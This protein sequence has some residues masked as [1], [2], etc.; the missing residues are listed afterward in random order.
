MISLYGGGAEKS[1]LTIIKMLQSLGYN[2]HVFS[3]L[4][5]ENA[6]ELKNNFKVYYLD[7]ANIK[8]PFS[9]QK[10]LALRRFLSD[11]KYNFIIDGRTRV[12]VIKEFFYQKIA[13]PSVSKKVFLVHSYHIYNYIFQN[14]NWNNFFYKKIH[15]VTVAKEIKNRLQNELHLKKVSHIPNALE[16]NDNFNQIES[17]NILTQDYI[18]YF[19]R[20]VD[21][22]KNVSFLIR[23]YLA[24]SLS[25]KGIKF[26]ILGSGIDETMLK[27][28][29]LEANKSDSV[30]FKSF[31]RNPEQYIKHAV[32]TVMASK[33]EGFPMTLIESLHLGIPVIATNFKSGPSEIISNG[34]NGILLQ[35]QDTESFKLA[36]EKMCFDK[37][38]RANCQNNSKKSV[39]KYNTE[40]ISKQWKILLENL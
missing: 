36:L 12:S 11:K 7:E 1:N 26:L 40:H 39:E 21:E 25:E 34:S 23:A 18:I 10:P 22:I 16:A 4:K 29:V 30:I 19:G 13:Y 35:H 28:Q 38:F 14:N 2:V 15:F 27:N 24:S 3:I 31:T 17:K 20:L 9:L 5:S 37:E 6:V 8:L 32:C 33:Y